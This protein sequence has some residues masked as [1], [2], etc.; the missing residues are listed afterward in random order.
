MLDEKITSCTMN[1]MQLGPKNFKKVWEQISSAKDIQILLF[2]LDNLG[3]G[4]YVKAFKEFVDYEGVDENLDIIK[5][6]FNEQIEDF[7]V[8]RAKKELTIKEYPS[9]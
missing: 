1:L 4:L 6:G 9:I 7:S 8:I 5:L 2:A 3:Y